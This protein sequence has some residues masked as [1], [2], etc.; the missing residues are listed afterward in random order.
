[1]PRECVGSRGNLASGVAAFACRLRMLM[2]QSH[3][4]GGDGRVVRWRGPWWRSAQLE[5]TDDGR[6]AG[7]ELRAAHGTDGDG[8]HTGLYLNQAGRG[9][10]MVNPAEFFRDEGASR[11][12]TLPLSVL[13]DEELVRSAQ[14]RTTKRPASTCSTSTAIWCGPR[15]SP[16]SSWGRSATISCRSA[17][18]ACG[19]PSTTSAPIAILRSPVSPRS[20][21]SAR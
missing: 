19:R 8:W 2:G 15:S 7:T 17:W 4:A 11:R 13:T 6:A 10:R 1:M 20:A 16:T 18:W 5:T 12:R 9:E 3:S 14:S 21:S